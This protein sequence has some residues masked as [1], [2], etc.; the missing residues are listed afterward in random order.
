MGFHIDRN[1]LKKNLGSLTE[2]AAVYLSLA[3]FATVFLLQQM[4]ALPAQS[5]PSPSARKLSSLQESFASE[6]IDHPGPHRKG[7]PLLSMDMEVEEVPCDGAIDEALDMDPV[8]AVHHTLSEIAYLG[9]V[10]S[11]LSHLDAT[12]RNMPHVPCFVLYH[13]WKGDMA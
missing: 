13:C 8:P 7:T 11:L 9:F 4:L 1:G 10:K 6:N 3:A 5:A 12:A 2:K